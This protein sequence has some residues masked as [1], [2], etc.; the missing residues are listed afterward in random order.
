[1]ILFSALPPFTYTSFY[2][3]R[4]LKNV[5]FTILI[6]Y[7]ICI[8]REVCRYTVEAATD[9]TNQWKKQLLST[10]VAKSWMVDLHA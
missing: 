2:V 1:M 10:F 6:S 9:N 8:H 7:L 5:D 3:W 4:E